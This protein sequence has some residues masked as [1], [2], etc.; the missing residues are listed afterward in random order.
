[1][2]LEKMVT[3][4]GMKL[5]VDTMPDR[6]VSK[7][8]VFVGAGSIHESEEQAGI[9]HALEHC[10]HLSTEKFSNE[11]ALN[12]FTGIHSL[13]ANADTYY[14]R[15]CYY[16]SGP[17]VEPNLLR[18]GELLFR[19]T[20]KEEYIPNELLVV[21]RE[22]HETRDDISRIHDVACEYSLFGKPYGRSVVGYADKLNYSAQEL[23][24]YYDRYYRMSNMAL[25]AVGNV[26]MDQ[27]ASGI[28]RHFEHE[29]KD[30]Y[31]KKLSNVK[32]V[33]ADRTGVFVND[34]ELAIV[35]VATPMD[36]QF[37]NKYLGD[38]GRYTA[39]MNAIGA[40][41][42][43]RFRID[44]GLSYD[45]MTHF[46][47]LNDPRAWSIGGNATVD[48][49]STKKADIL[50]RD[51]LS[52]TS[53]AYSDSA[54]DSAIGLTIGETITS[55]DAVADRMELYIQ[56]LEQQV[57]PVDLDIRSDSVK[58]LTREG[59]RL[60]IDEIVEYIA[61]HPPKVHITGSKTAIKSVDEVIDITSFA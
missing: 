27:I 16:A 24:E 23:S 53:D 31:A 54:V 3:A 1:M 40:L 41:C 35:R 12:E 44:T 34:D 42:Y 28:D 5:Y 36:R 21:T 22:A 55:M 59:V 48:P 51:V 39:A 10:V 60:A 29:R 20:F 56:D 13:D 32:H 30:T 33:S 4:E 9:S 7:I 6:N 19:A 49:R 38:K 18:L 46:Y 52:H 61:E 47:D 58:R 26:N 50:L 45:G 8:N 17:Q 2:A 14:T 11:E 57:E 43:K 37:A 15:T 25:V